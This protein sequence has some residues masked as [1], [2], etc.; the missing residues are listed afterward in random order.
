MKELKL[1]QKGCALLLSA[2]LAAGCPGAQLYMTV[3][4]EETSQAN[5]R[6]EAVR[7]ERISLKTMPSK[8]EYVVGELFDP[9][10][11]V[12]QLHYSDGSVE[13][14]EKGFWCSS[15]DTGSIG[16]KEVTV[17]Y[18]RFTASFYIT[19]VNLVVEEYRYTPPTRTEYRQFDTFDP[20]GLSMTVVYNNGRTETPAVTYTE[21][22]MSQTGKQTISFRWG[23][24]IERFTFNLVM[25]DLVRLSYSGLTKT[26]YSYGEELDLSTLVVTAYFAHGERIEVTDYTVS[27]YN[28]LIEREQ[29]VA[30]TYGGMSVTFSVRVGVEDC[31]ASAFLDVDTESWYHDGIDYVL[32]NGYMVGISSEL[33]APDAPTNRA[34]IVTILWRMEGCPDVSHEIMFADVPENAWFTKA[35]AW[36]SSKGIV[37]GYSDSVF[38]PNDPINRE[39]LATMIY[40]YAS[41]SGMDTS[42]RADLSAMPDLDAISLWALDAISWT[43]AEGLIVGIPQTNTVSRIDPKGNATRAQ[44]AAIMQRFGQ[45]A[46]GS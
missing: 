31:P 7:V 22:D 43:H 35:I 3:Y 33:F 8:T 23:N 14:L 9:A 13:A 38:G 4:A 17:G 1:I 24:H 19:V 45:V 34:M 29:E 41:C 6:E 36:A 5:A 37:S 10:G 21:P 18:E 40:R 42:S 30:I 26:Q 20:T 2:C 15:P 25:K 32:E 46:S 27:G 12:I 28:P 44:V 16:K 39:Q 11:L